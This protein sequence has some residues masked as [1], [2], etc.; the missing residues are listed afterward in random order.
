MSFEIRAFLAF[1][2]SISALETFRPVWSVIDVCVMDLPRSPGHLSVCL[3]EL[4]HHLDLPEVEQLLEYRGVLTLTSIEELDV[5]ESQVLL[6]DLVTCCRI[7]RLVD[8]SEFCFG[9]LSLFVFRFVR[10][11][12]FMDVL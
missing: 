6:Q 9:E 4:L 7:F 10:S 11:V 1:F 5:V 2:G 8:S 12:D 3:L